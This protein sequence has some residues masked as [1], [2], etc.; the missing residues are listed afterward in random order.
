[1]DHTDPLL[2]G[3]IGLRF[4]FK[5]HR[6]HEHDQESETSSDGGH[7]TSERF[8]TSLGRSATAVNG[9]VVVC[10]WLFRLTRSAGAYLIGDGRAT[11][12]E[13]GTVMLIEHRTFRSASEPARLDYRSRR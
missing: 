11:M 13:N 3:A 9:V 6:T 1:M 2:S 12:R 7:S 4:H 8:S 5:K 10:V